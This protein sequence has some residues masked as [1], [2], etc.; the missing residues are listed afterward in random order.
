M[1]HLI[2]GMAS[3]SFL[4]LAIGLLRPAF[5]TDYPRLFRCEIVEQS[6]YDLNIIARNL[7]GYG[8]SEG[9]FECTVA[10]AL[11]YVR[12]DGEG[13]LKSRL[14]LLRIFNIW[15]SAQEVDLNQL[16]EPLV[17]MEERS[18]YP[19]GL[20]VEDYFMIHLN[21]KDYILVSMVLDE[22]R[23]SGVRML[24]DGVYQPNNES[25]SVIMDRASIDKGI[26]EEILAIKDQSVSK[27]R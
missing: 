5:A 9:F 7:K 18:N 13:V 6:V 4:L 25:R 19:V 3:V 1:N 8:G 15:K 12:R 21:E 27:V 11:F 22:F 24:F 16:N 17:L 14:E 26:L 20:A 23:L 10:S 2:R